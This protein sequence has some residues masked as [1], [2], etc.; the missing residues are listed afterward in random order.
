MNRGLS[1]NVPMERYELEA[2]VAAAQRDLRHPRDQARYLL[3]VALLG[4]QPGERAARSDQS[5]QQ[6]IGEPA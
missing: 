2:L 1:V 5:P 4:D 6:I 3:R